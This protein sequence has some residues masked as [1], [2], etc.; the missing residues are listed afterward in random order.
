MDAALSTGGITVEVWADGSYFHPAFA[1]HFSGPGGAIDPLC[2]SVYLSVCPDHSLAI[3][4]SFLTPAETRNS[5][6]LDPL[7]KV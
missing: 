1:D 4:H 2:E 6:V 5:T 7:R 3:R